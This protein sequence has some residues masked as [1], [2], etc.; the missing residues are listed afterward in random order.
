MIKYGI[1]NYN[2]YFNKQIL[3]PK[4]PNVFINHLLFKNDI[5]TSEDFKN[6]PISITKR[7][8][9]KNLTIL[10]YRPIKNF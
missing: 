4:L 10:Y 5:N 9:S 7:I 1:S 6:L 8:K 2:N 3:I